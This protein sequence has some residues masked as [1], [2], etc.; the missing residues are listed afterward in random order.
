M[1]ELMSKAS[2]FKT[3]RKIYIVHNVSEVNLSLDVLVGLRI[4]NEFFP[5]AGAGNQ[6]GA[7]AEQNSSLTHHTASN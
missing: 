1:R 7:Q 3:S 4:V 5:A 2:R 6:H